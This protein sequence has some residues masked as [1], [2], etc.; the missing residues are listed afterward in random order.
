MNDSTKVSRRTMLANCGRLAAGFFTVPLGLLFASSAAAIIPRAPVL[1]ERL[2]VGLRVKLKRD[3]EF[4]DHVVE[5]VVTGKLPIK[6]VDQTYFW[7]RT[8][9][10]QHRT[11]QNNPMVFFRPGLRARAAKIGVRV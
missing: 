7:A 5:L 9:A 10:A 1:R 3:I 11:L 2:I 4:I 8:K 6:L